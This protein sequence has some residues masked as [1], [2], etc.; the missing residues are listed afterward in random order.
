MLKVA[1]KELRE[2]IAR[3]NGYLRRNE[4]TRAL[5][6]MSA[7]L[8]QY[9]GVQLMRGPRA[10]MDIQIC[11]FLNA[12]THHQ[13]MQPLLDPTHSG[14]PKS[15][16]YQQGKEAAIATVLEG[17]AKIM[18]NEAEEKVRRE[19]EARLERKK[20]LIETGI[21]LLNDGQ[22]AQRRAT[23]EEAARRPVRQG[24]RLPQAR[25][26]G[27]QRGG[28]HSRPARPDFRGCGAARGSR[29]NV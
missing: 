1:P 29:G 19:A 27:I 23:C 5:G 16:P 2:N 6:A 28:R 14:K 11:E 17:L 8:R 13:A 12:L 24:T 20:S 22:Y 10:E 7:A 18:V 4:V 21:Q 15:I 9:A 25:G 26:R 3:A